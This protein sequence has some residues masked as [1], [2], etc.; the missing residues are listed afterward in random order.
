MTAPPVASRAA[1][2]DTA[3]GAPAQLV[4][5]RRS[6]AFIPELESVRGIA[7]LLVFTFHVDSFARFPYSVVQST[8]LSLA[9]VRAGFTGVD[10][11]FV[12]S[13]FLLS[14]P[15]LADAAGGR[16]V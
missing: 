7:V 13:G 4:G 15:F 14:L 11:F 2:H 12:L 1:G 6:S 9:F 8:P 10:L 16:R 3:A 5:L